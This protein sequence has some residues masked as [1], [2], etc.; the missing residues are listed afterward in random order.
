MVGRFL[1]ENWVEK[2]KGRKKDD[3]EWGIQGEM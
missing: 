2:R 1:I 3:V